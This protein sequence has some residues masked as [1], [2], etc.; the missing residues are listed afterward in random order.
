MKAARGVLSSNDA[1]KMAVQATARGVSTALAG[2][3]RA[4]PAYRHGNL[5]RLLDPSEDT[6]HLLSYVR[7]R[8]RSRAGPSSGGKWRRRAYRSTVLNPGDWQ[9]RGLET[10][11]AGLW[12]R[13]TPLAKNHIWR[14][15]RVNS[16]FD[17][18]DFPVVLHTHDAWPDL[19][20]FVTSVVI[21]L[22]I[23]RKK[24]E[25]KGIDWLAHFSRY[26][27]PALWSQVAPDYF[28]GSEVLPESVKSDGLD[29]R[30][31]ELSEKVTWALN[32]AF[33]SRIHNRLNID[34]SVDQKKQEL[35]VAY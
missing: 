16:G 33:T 26:M 10:F 22:I 17:P 28:K 23:S 2:R 1:R 13:A 21:R 19:D 32:D 30:R 34:F 35:R 18:N 3:S 12:S 14:S 8:P 31:G 5:R 29:G 9:K 6:I 20:S 15:W 7:T 4:T 24:F 27:N 11:P 25:N